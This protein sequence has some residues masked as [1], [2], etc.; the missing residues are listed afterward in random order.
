MKSIFEEPVIDQLVVTERN[1]NF[2]N[3]IDR[4]YIGERTREKLAEANLLF[5]P[6]EDYGDE[7][8]VCFPKGTADLFHFF[9]KS[10]SKELNVDICIEDDDYK[11]LAL[12]SELLIIAGIVVAHLLAPIAVNLISKYIIERTGNRAEKTTV[13]T[14]LTVLI[15]K[16]SRSIE[17]SYHGPANEYQKVMTNALTNIKSLPGTESLQIM[18]SDDSRAMDVEKSKNKKKKPKK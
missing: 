4:P 9:V 13:K 10:E 7:D 3:W 1:L 11:E 12:Y 8:I 5:V 18:A 16:E 6:D 15:E 2:D 17:Y 14:K